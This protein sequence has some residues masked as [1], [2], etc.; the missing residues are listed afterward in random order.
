MFGRRLRELERE[1][2]RERAEWARERER[3]VNH[4][5]QL[6]G[7][8]P[9]EPPQGVRVPDKPPAEPIVLTAPEM[10]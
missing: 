3:L 8:P 2:A 4:I 6:A 5:L 1:H 7:K 10:I 9:L